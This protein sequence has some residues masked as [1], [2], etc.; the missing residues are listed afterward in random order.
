MP[1]VHLMVHL[2]WISSWDPLGKI[3]ELTVFFGAGSESP[4]ESAV[5]PS[6]IVA[7]VKLETVTTENIQTASE[8]SGPGPPAAAS[9][10]RAAA[11][12]SLRAAGPAAAAPAPWQ[13]N[14]RGYQ[15]GGPGP[16]R[17]DLVR[18]LG[19]HDQ[20]SKQCLQFSG[21][22]REGREMQEMQ[23]RN[24]QP[25]HRAWASGSDSDPRLG[26]W[27]SSCPRSASGPAG[28]PPGPA[29]GA[30]FKLAVGLVSR[31]GRAAAGR[32]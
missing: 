7:P 6:G 22:E 10:C 24:A 4:A 18:R 29:A 8:L 28:R 21:S 9:A 20:Q 1:I 26:A 14:A 5:G 17:C 2:R 23:A 31:P 32:T 11:F 3:S 12:V 19:P 25:L 16:A 15:P 13:R 30:A 27:L